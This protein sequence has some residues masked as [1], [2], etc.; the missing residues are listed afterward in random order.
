MSE[1]LTKK[2]IEKSPKNLQYLRDKDKERVRG[3]FIYNEVP[4]GAFSFV[5]KKYKGDPI[6]R[7]DLIDGGIYT[8]PLGVAKHLN[9]N[10]WYPI[11]AYTK[12]ENGMPAQKI[13]Q[14]VH[15]TAFQSLEFVDIED[16]GTQSDIVT[17]EN[18]II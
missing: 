18:V 1:N 10:T 3:K 5:F 8:L 14:K 13:G 11:H 2:K 7:Y 4:G 15:R 12:D 9:N 16:L 6:E 17:V